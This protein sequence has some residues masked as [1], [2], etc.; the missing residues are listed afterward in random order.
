VLDI[1]VMETNTVATKLTI[2]KNRV[3]IK[4]PFSLESEF[5]ERQYRLALKVIAELH[6]PDMLTRRGE[7]FW[8]SEKD[9][10]KFTIT[11]YVQ[12][13][14]NNHVDPVTFEEV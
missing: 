8:R 9:G 4:Y 3:T 14:K 5:R 6:N 1:E 10:G 2:A 13:H 7:F 11:M 12:T